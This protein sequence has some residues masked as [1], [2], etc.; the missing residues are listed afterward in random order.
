MFQDTSGIKGYITEFTNQSP[1]DASSI[2]TFYTYEHVVIHEWFHVDRF[3]FAKPHITD[4]D[5][6]LLFD[7]TG[8]MYR[9]YGDACCHQFSW[10]T[11][12]GG[13]QPLAVA[14]GQYQ[15]MLCSL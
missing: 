11:S 14:N 9:I 2:H 4:I 3:G 13:V 5:S 10:E 8:A 1:Q 7:R 15:I 12:T 6:T